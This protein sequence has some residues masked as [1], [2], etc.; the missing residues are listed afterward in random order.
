MDRIKLFIAGRVHQ[1]RSK[2]FFLKTQV[3]YLVFL[4]T[5]I[6]AYASMGPVKTVG[7]LTDGPME[8]SENIRAVFEAE[9]KQLTAGDFVLEFPDAARIDGGWSLE[10]ISA[11]LD[12]LETDPNV[13]VVLVLGLAAGRLAAQQKK[14]QKPTFVP[15][16]FN[17][18]MFTIS[19]KGTGRG[20]RHLNYLGVESHFDRDLAIFQKVVPFSRLGVLVDGLYFKAFPDAVRQAEQIA[21]AHEVTII[22]IIVESPEDDVIMKIPD[23]VEAVMISA[24][25]RFNGNAALISGLIRRKLPSFTYDEKINVEKGILMA[26]EK[27]VDISRRARR[28]AVNM[29]T[30]LKGGRPENQPKGFERNRRLTVNMA[31]ARKINVYPSFEILKDAV[32]LHEQEKPTHPAL[33]LSDAA[34]EAVQTN[35]DIIAGQIG[36]RASGENIAEARS[37]L[38]PQL[39]VHA[40]YTQLND[41]NQYVTTGF[42]AEKNTAGGLRLEQMI[43]SERALANLTIAKQLQLAAE[44]QQRGLELD[45]IEQATTAFLNIL[46]AQTRVRI[47][48]DNLDL[49][50]SNLDLAKNRVAVGA[51]DASDIYRWESEIANVRANLLAVK[52]SEQQ[53]RD[54]LN[55]ILH[56]PLTDRFETQPAT[57]D[58]PELLISRKEL[59]DTVADERAY[60]LTA[61]FFIN[62]GMAASPE[63][64]ALNARMAAKKREN[65]SDRRAYWTPQI[66]IYSEMT[67]VF[68][69]VR[70]PLAAISMDDETNW[71]AGVQMVL[72][73]Y[74]G[75]GRNARQKRSALG[76][77]QLTIAYQNTRQ[78]LEQMIRS[79]LH[80]IRATYPAIDLSAQSAEAARKNYEL[81]RDNYREGTRNITDLLVSQN[82]RLAANQASANAVY[83]FLLDLMSLQRH[84]GAF[85]F[86]LDN[87]AKNQTIDQ[88]KTYIA[89]NGNKK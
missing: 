79:D 32:V 44:A 49:T 11:G 6:T 73:L 22:W 23:T 46:M 41:D 1:L 72:P 19:G 5:C 58:D 77:K 18:D 50:Q 66:Q 47:Q 20:I 24:L 8:D 61:D 21:A 89:T 33:T 35:L 59:L 78:I 9:I 62:Q 12:L 25:P 48:K 10:K 29:A 40:G 55:R 27:P 39:S 88:L 28:L 81:V 51:T 75:G 26:P 65:T 15:F 87:D 67:H 31:T 17:A 36:L 53:A 54:A 43:F 14:L 42:Y 74:E 85:D 86:F 34:R 2:K 71:E 3:A 84:I 63:L 76:L 57:L 56:R 16:G 13:D 38:F 52:A 37:I 7:I 83:R 30:L 64:S 4:L 60:L 45:I 70:E 69:E 80:H 82:A 68:D